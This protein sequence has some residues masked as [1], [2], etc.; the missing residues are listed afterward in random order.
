[1][2]KKSILSRSKKDKEKKIE[3]P[4]AQPPS[5][6]GSKTFQ[7]KEMKKSV[8]TTTQSIAQVPSLEKLG[9]KKDDKKPPKMDDGY[10][11]FGPGA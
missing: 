5:K 3:K 9:A 8:A 11:D 10:E 2:K 4:L 7:R 6:G 1:M